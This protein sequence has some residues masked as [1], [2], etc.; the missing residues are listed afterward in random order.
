MPEQE[1]MGAARFDPVM[2]NDVAWFCIRSQQKHEQLAARQLY[3]T[4]SAISHALKAFEESVGKIL[5]ERTTRR[6]RLTGAAKDE[7]K[8]S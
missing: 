8:E 2:P 5:F 4:P 6:L 1:L 3:L 7:K